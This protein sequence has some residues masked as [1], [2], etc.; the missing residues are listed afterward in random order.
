M[1]FYL[2]S[3]CSPAQVGSFTSTCGVL[4][5]DLA[6]LLGKLL[7]QLVALLVD[8]LALLVNLVVTL[9]FTSSL[10]KVY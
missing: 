4:L 6:V 9:E 5:V 10:S 7:G 1:Y 2:H 3:G 8:L